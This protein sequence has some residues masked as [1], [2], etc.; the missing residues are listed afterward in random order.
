VES[1]YT[2]LATQ[3]ARRLAKRAGDPEAAE[4]ER[5]RA[6]ATEADR[7]GKI[8]DLVRKYSLRVRIAPAACLLTALPVREIPVLLIRKKE[9]RRRVVHWNPALRLLEPLLCEACFGRARPLYLCEKVHCLCKECWA[10]CAAC[11]KSFCRACQTRCR[12]GASA[13]SRSRR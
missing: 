12:C 4:K 10:P 11:G 7:Q 5:S 6:A 9:E 3:I 1:Y 2:G 8:E 13:A